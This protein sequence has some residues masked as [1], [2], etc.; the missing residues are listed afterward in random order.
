MKDYFK[1]YSLN[2]LIFFDVNWDYTTILYININYSVIEN[3]S[4][5]SQLERKLP[6][7]YENSI[8]HGK[9]L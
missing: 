2:Y 4:I 8:L 5:C 1:E 7:E 6:V 9:K 3:V